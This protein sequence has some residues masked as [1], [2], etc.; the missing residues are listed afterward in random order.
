MKLNDWLQGL[1]HCVIW[2]GFVVLCEKLFADSPARSAY[3]LLCA[4]WATLY[5]ASVLGTRWR[6]IV[7]FLL[8]MTVAL[9]TGAAASSNLLY[10]DTPAPLS[11][12]FIGVAGLL[13]VLWVS[14]FAI[15]SAVVW[16]RDRIRRS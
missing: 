8:G 14:P 2:I 11:V 16:V 3:G 12:G 7:V 10:R 1:A 4:W 5:S 15:N 13:W 6:A 9:A